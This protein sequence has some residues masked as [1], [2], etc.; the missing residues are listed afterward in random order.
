MAKQTEPNLVADAYAK[1]LLELA[2]EQGQTS[3]IA[4]EL[5]Q[6]AEVI[7][8]NKSFAMYLADPGIGQEERKQTLGRLFDGKVSPLM[9]NF[10]GVLNVRN[11]LVIL[12]AIAAAFERQLEEQ[13]GN[14]EV[15]VTTA[16]KLSPEDLEL[17]RQK[18]SSALGKNAIVHQYVDESILGGLVVRVQDKLIDASVRYQL[19][20]MKEQLLA[21]APR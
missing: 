11:K 3:E 20:A 13:R 12:P 4:E 18:V 21:A 15:D 17:V 8:Q 6:L 19:Q 9:H 14:I 7:A 5:S 1:P 16:Q 10:L 2:T